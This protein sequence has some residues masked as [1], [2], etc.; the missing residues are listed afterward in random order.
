MPQLTL[1]R[2]QSAALRHIAEASVKTKKTDIQII[3]RD[4]FNHCFYICLPR[5]DDPRNVREI[6]REA[7]AKEADCSTDLIFLDAYADEDGKFWVVGPNGRG[8]GEAEVSLADHEADKR[9]R[10]K[11]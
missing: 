4:F 1:P 2:H 9:R 10:E 3:C 11:L 7:Y 5:K 6:I 8:L